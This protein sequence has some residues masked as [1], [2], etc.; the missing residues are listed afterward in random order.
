MNGSYFGKPGSWIFSSCFLR[1]P[2]AVVRCNAWTAITV[3]MLESLPPFFRHCL[4][5]LLL[6]LASIGCLPSH[7]VV[8]PAWVRF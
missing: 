2:P 8:E 4:H 3:L 1:T 7:P 6:L 5:C